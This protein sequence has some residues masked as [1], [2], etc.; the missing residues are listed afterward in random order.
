MSEDAGHITTKHLMG[1]GH[2]VV[3]W[4]AL[5]IAL[6]EVLRTLLKIDDAMALLTF[7]HSGYNEKRTRIV[8]LA[9]VYEL[10]EAAEKE[11]DCL[12]TRM[13]AAYDLRNIVAHSVW[14]AG[15]KPGEIVPHILKAKSKKIKLSGVNLDN[16]VFT[17]ERLRGEALK[18]G[19]VVEDVQDFFRAHFGAS[20]GGQ[21][22]GAD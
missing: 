13:N 11:L 1:I 4:A 20:F 10:S 16:E 8:T 5:E 12:V 17:P 9:S 18:I 21:E 19:R 15:D 22:D 6:I 7:Y 14:A 3:A 2:V